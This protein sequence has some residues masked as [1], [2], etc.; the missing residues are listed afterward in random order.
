[1]RGVSPALSH[2]HFTARLNASVN[3]ITDQRYIKTYLLFL[4]VFF[5][6]SF[7]FSP[8]TPRIFKK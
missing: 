3:G 6:V 4:L 5:S 8:P 2:A 7:Y 1:M